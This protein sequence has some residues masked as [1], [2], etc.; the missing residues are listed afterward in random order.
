MDKITIDNVKDL[1]KH[2]RIKITYLNKDNKPITKTTRFYGIENNIIMVYIPKKQK[3][4]WE[5]P[6]GSECIIKKIA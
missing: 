2:D 4:V 1:Q 5:I 3:Q 6:E